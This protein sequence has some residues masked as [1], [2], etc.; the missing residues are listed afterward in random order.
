MQRYLVVASVF[1]LSLITYVDRAAISSAKGA[2]TS[3]LALSDQAMG[4]VFSAFALGY[5]FAQIPAGWFADKVGPRLALTTIVGLWSLFTALTGVVDQFW[6]LLT[7]RFLFGVAEAGAF[8]GAARVFYNWLP[9]GERGLANGA[10]FSGGL[11]G[12]A[13]AF[14]FFAWLFAAYGWRGAFYALSAPGF[15]WAALWFFWFRDRPSSSA[16]EP[17]TTAT[18]VPFGRLLRSRGMLLLMFQYFAQN[19]TF[20]IC[21]SWMYPLLT[22]RYGLSAA[23]AARYAMVPLLCGAT[24]NWVAGFLVDLLYRTALR[25]WSRQLPAMFGFSLATMGVWLASMARSP[26]G[27]VGAFALATFGVEMTISPSWAHCLD[28]GGKSRAPS[29]GP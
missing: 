24:A 3:D 21:I 13:L 8:P 28:V 1:M 19:F 4:A 2:I 6:T 25:P 23:Q 27:A 16:P 14:P 12:G 22:D 20:F 7:V 15:L 29:R 17:P 18:P 11:L 26:E 10:L 5:A 9:P